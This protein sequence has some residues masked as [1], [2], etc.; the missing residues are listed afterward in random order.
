[1]GRVAEIHQLIDQTLALGKQPN[2]DP[3]SLMQRAAEELLAHGQI[4]GGRE[5][6]RRAIGYYQPEARDTA[7]EPASLW[8]LGNVLFLAG[9]IDSA[10]RI[11]REAT[12]RGRIVR[13]Q[14]E[15]FEGMVAASD[16]RRAEAEA[17]ADS[18]ATSAPQFNVFDASIRIYYRARIAAQLGEPDRAISLLQE[19]LAAGLPGN[20]PMD[21]VHIEPPL[22]RLRGHPAFDA[23]V[24]LDDR[25]SLVARTNSRPQ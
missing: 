23:M 19:S 21:S 3:G 9:E 14:V 1:M 12:R 16:G 11:Y 7:A 25:R 13:Y 4:G 10:R 18:L 15:G 24:R 17:W 5:V 22:Y 8:A 20:V 2:L 6:L